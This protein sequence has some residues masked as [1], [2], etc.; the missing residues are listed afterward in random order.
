MEIIHPSGAIHREKLDGTRIDYY[1]QPEY[2]IHYSQIPPGTVQEWH[3]HNIV[4]EA[5]L[6]VEGQLEIRWVADKIVK[7]AKVKNG[8]LIRVEN[9]PHTFANITAKDAVFVV[10]KA[11]LKGE[12]NS[13]IFREDKIYTNLTK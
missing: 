4:E 10:F 12:D 3:Q 9:T 6:I 1:F 11:I 2:E 13:K 5:I 8:D 7:K